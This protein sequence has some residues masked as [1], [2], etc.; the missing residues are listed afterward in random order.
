MTWIDNITEWTGLSISTLLPAAERREQWNTVCG[1]ASDLT[2]Y[3]PLTGLWI[4]D[5]DKSKCFR[6][7][8]RIFSPK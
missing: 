7:M 3:D 4:Y 5:D 1:V 2:F 6:M 8:K